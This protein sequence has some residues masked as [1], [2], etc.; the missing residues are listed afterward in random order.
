MTSRGTVRVWVDDEGWGV[1]DSPDTP[2]GCWTHVS[3][4]HVPGYRALEADQAVELEWEAPGQDGYRYRAVRA[5]PAGQDPG[6]EPEAVT[7]PSE[8]YRSTLTLVRDED[9]G[10]PPP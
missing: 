5:W 8:A 7:G 4:L 3:A 9:P 1:I 2:G 6:P 10:V